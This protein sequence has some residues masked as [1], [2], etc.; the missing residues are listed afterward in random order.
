MERALK[1]T[2]DPAWVLVANGYDL[3]REGNLESRFAIS[4]GFLGV[5]GSRAATRGGH[6]IVPP[7][8]YV[9][10]LFDTPGAEGA[11]P[12]LIPAADW[13]HVHIL[14]PNGALVHHPGDVSS[15]RTT[16]DVRR[17]V[18]FTEFGQLK[19]PDVGMRVRTARLVSLN[20]RAVGIQLIRMEIEEGEVEVTLEASFEGLNLGLVPERLEQDLGVWRTLRSGKRLAM[21]TAAFLQVDGHDLPPTPLGQLK[22]SWS[23]KSRPGQVVCFERFVAVVRSDAQGLDPGGGARHKIDVARQLGWRRAIDEHEAAWANRWRCSQVEVDGDAAAQKALRFAIYH[24][25]SAANPADEHVSIGARALTGDDY[26]GHVFWD[27][28]IFLLPFFILTWPEAA[29]A[30]LMYRFHTLDAARTKA[31]GMGWRGALYAWESTDTGIETTPEHAIAPDRQIIDILCGKQEQHISAD[32]AY[33]VW[34]Y[35]Q[36]T[37]DDAFLRDAGAEILIETGRFWS[38]RARLEADGRHHIRGVIGPDEYH[39]HIDDNA[40]T[41][42][43]ARWNIRRALDVATL[44]RERWPKL[45]TSLSSRLGLDDAELEQWRK[46]AETMATGFDAK[47]G[48]F[49]QFAG[50]FTLEEI[51][52]SAYAGRSVPMDVVLGRERTRQSQVI[53]QADVVALLGLLPEEFGGETAAKNFLYYEARCDHGSSLS[54]AMHG[55]VAARLG[56]SDVALC[57]FRQTAAIDLADTHAAIGGG[58]HIAALGG[59]WLMAVFGFAGISLQNDSVAVDPK[60]PTDWR[61]LGFR[62]QW[63]GRHL[64]MSID[65]TEQHVEAT[66]EAGEPMMLVVSNERQELCLGKTLRVGIAK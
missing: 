58:V 43:M 21:A 46:V 27:T 22:C 20:E 50:F 13:L 38:S 36:A 29:R 12:G 23:W 59:V 35:W 37:G 28:E 53:K 42:V 18:L 51:D 44:L 60:L 25:N 16:L 62:L 26:R 41:N 61:S 19:P 55:M 24:L 2:F 47:S 40:F 6:W 39:V 5:R 11:T 57:Y 31:A 1:P 17:G 32:I 9:A 7:R 48:L 56:F 65:Q 3:L 52:L 14:L 15:H 10:G 66:L 8:T 45:W 54:P 49:E 4:N 33:A 30:L 34:Q 63:R 64:K